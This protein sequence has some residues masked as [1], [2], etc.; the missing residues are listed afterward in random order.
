MNVK[1]FGTAAWTALLKTTLFI[2]NIVFFALGVGFLT[3]GIY[4][5]TVFK[6]FFSF[7]PSNYIYTPFICIGLF[8]MIVGVLSLWCTP[9]GVTWLLYLYGII[10]FVL[11]VA[12]LILSAAFVVKRDTF[13]KTLETGIKKAMEDYPK[14]QQSIDLL[15][16]TLHCCGND[17]Y[18]EWFT[19]KWAAG[20][21]NVPTSCCTKAAGTKCVHLDLSTNL[22]DIYQAGCYKRVYTTIEDNYVIIGSI[23]FVS[24]IIIFFGS[25]LA[26]GLA[27]NLRKNSYEQVE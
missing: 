15:Q 18:T 14:D 2:F 21:N 1:Q 9:K 23:G 13:E 4:G 7:A 20:E 12:V 27:Q 22:T 10:V 24:S 5:M 6:D 3:I 25:L 16:E 11:F 19:T 8:M 26:C 17:N